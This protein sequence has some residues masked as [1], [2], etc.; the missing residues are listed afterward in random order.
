MRRGPAHARSTSDAGVVGAS[1]VI[2]RTR[3][4]TASL[5]P[6]LVAAELGVEGSKPVTSIVAITS[7]EA[8]CLGL[9][10][11]TL[12]NA[13]SLSRLSLP[14]GWRRGSPPQRD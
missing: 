2:A 4:A 1:S 10:S 9:S 6:S 8:S 13:R 11:W 5:R 7:C 3:V 14:R 12:F